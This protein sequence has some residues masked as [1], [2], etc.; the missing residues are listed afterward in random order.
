MRGE[1]GSE[2]GAVGKKDCGKEFWTC[3]KH[4]LN[5]DKS[6]SGTFSK[7]YRVLRFEGNSSIIE[8]AQE[9]FEARK[10]KKKIKIHTEHPD[11]CFGQSA[12]W[13]FSHKCLRSWRTTSNS[14]VRL[15]CDENRICTTIDKGGKKEKEKNRYDN[16]KTDA[17][18]TP[19]K[20]SQ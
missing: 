4:W 10:K 5:C 17:T 14:Q 1:E 20:C 2:K 15:W 13:D 9:A 3:E 7:A 18:M 19:R 16:S 12:S 6:D 11:H 8:T